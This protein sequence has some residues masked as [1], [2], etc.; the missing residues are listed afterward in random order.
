MA[1]RCQKLAKTIKIDAFLK[2]SEETDRD[3]PRLLADAF[4]AYLGAVYLDG[5]FQKAK[6][7]IEDIFSEKIKAKLPSTDYKSTLQEWCQ[8]KYQTNPI[9]RLKN[10]EGPEHKKMFFMEVLLSEKLL[11]EGKDSRKK[12]AEQIAAKEAIKNLKIPLLDKSS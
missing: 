6:K 5:G 7:I 11:G 1:K 8:K 12:D 10:A 2:A 3:N 4:E 9:Y